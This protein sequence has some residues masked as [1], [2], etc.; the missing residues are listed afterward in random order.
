MMLLK[1]YT[2]RTEVLILH[3]NRSDTFF[4]VNSTVFLGREHYAYLSTWPFRVADED[5]SLNM[6]LDELDEHGVC[7]IALP[8]AD[9]PPGS[10]HSLPS[11]TS[12]PESIVRCL[13]DIHRAC[14]SPNYTAAGSP[15]ASDSERFMVTI[16]EPF[17]AMVALTGVL[18]EYSAVYVPA[19]GSEREVFLANV[20]LHVVTV[21]LCGIDNNIIQR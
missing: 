5:R 20:P 12:P 14:Q 10:H 6:L 1:S 3:E 15:S 21:E 18:L 19:K 17:E 11:F 4:L 2:G 8:S 16:A 9:R 7:F 13:D